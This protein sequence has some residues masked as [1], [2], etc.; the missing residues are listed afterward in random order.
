M[1]IIRSL[2]RTVGVAVFTIVETL[3]LGIWLA[4]VRDAPTLSRLALVGAG[5]LLAGLVLEALINTVVVNGFSFRL[6]AIATFSLSEALI[7][8]LWLGVAERL[9]GL[10]GVGIAG[11]VLFVLMLP[12]HS[13]EDN[14]LRGRG[15]F[16]SLVTPGTALF[17]FVEALGGTVWLAL[18]FRP[19]LLAAAGV[20][21]VPFAAPMVGDLGASVGL[22][23]LALALFVEHE[24]G[25]QFALR[26]GEPG[27]GV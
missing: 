13:I 17:T 19:D 25:L 1:T 14:V 5:I 11:V 21:S 6:G 4:L 3:T 20:D 7:W 10:T 23:L 27:P 12:Q 16:S 2:G 26:T 24:M 9:G 18:V 15:L 8:I 22:L